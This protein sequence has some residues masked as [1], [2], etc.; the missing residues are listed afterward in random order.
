MDSLIETV[1]TSHS[2]S[3]FKDP[4]NKKSIEGI[5]IH[6]SKHILE[7]RNLYVVASVCFKNGNTEGEQKIQAETFDECVQKIQIFI[8]SLEKTTGGT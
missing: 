8:D 1:K 7:P 5:H 2:I 6:I 4:F 3:I